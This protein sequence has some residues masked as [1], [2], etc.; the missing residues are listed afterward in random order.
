[1]QAAPG[2]FYFLLSTFYLHPAPRTMYL[3]TFYLHP[4][5]CTAHPTPC[6]P[7]SLFLLFT[8]FL[9]PTRH[10]TPCTLFLATTPHTLHLYTF[11][12]YL[13]PCTQHPTPS[14]LFPLY[15]S[16]HR[17]PPKKNTSRSAPYIKTTTQLG[18]TLWVQTKYNFH[19]CQIKLKR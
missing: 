13:T 16:P 3:F 14:A 6:T 5:S 19:L 2:T 8:F 12:L 4:A 9:H 10:S 1:M 11:T 15:C 18:C 17:P 7:H